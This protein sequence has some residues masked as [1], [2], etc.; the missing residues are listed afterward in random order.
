MEES[1]APAGPL[2]QA[3]GQQKTA[4]FGSAVAATPLWISRVETTATFGKSK[5]VL[6]P[7]HSQSAAVQHSRRN[8]AVNANHVPARSNDLIASS[9]SI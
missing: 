1:R 6:Q 3:R 2:N 5:A 4:R 8:T 9:S 7:P